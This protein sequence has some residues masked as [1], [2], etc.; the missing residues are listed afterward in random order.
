MPE[1]EHKSE[2]EKLRQNAEFLLK[3]R[4]PDVGSPFS[5]I[6]MLTLIHELE[7][8][9]IE[10]E[11]QNHELILS[12]NRAT[13]A[14]D[15]Y[16][17]LYDFAPVGYFTL[18]KEGEILE[19]NLLGAKM[20]GKER[21][22]IKRKRIG[23]YVSPGSQTIFNNFLKK[24]F[25][26][27]IKENCEITLLVQ[28][29]DAIILHAS[30]VISESGKECLLTVTDITELKQNEVALK[31]SI[32]K[33]TKIAARVPGVVYQ[34][35]LHPDG[36]SCFPYSSEAMKIIYGVTPEDIKEDASAVFAVIHPD[37]YNNLAS[38][39]AK[40]AKDLSPWQHEY[41][42][43]IN[44]GAIRHLLGSALP[45]L[46][47]D[48]SVLWHGFITDITN[49]VE[50]E[51]LLS[52]LGKQNTMAQQIGHTGSW[53]Y[54]IK[55]DKITGSEEAFKI[56]GL[57]NYSTHF[58]L[59]EIED[60]I[61]DRERVHQ[62]MV[63]L[64]KDGTEYHLQYVIQPAD[65]SNPKTVLSIAQL[66]MDTNGQ[67]IKVMGY[68]QDISAFIK[69]QEE[70]EFKN[71]QLYKAIAEKDKF[72]SIIAHDLRSPFNGFLGLTQL[73]VDDL[74]T[75][76]IVQIRQMAVLMRNSAVNV[77]SLLE[78]LLAW[79]RMQRGLI[80]FAPEK[81]NLR[82]KVKRILEPVMESARKKE[83]ETLWNIPEGIH[84]FADPN[85]F[86]SIMRNLVGNAVKF[87]PT[88]GKFIISAR[89]IDATT[90]EISVKDNGIGMCREMLENLFDMNEH[91]NRLGTDGEL[92]S[93]LGLLLCKEFTELNGG[94][95]W[96]ESIENGG[97]TFYFTV[98]MREG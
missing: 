67:P 88:G 94:K 84:F 93:G 1:N 7:V 3:K 91:N 38:S 20:L 56:F 54:E 52:K 29:K 74:S 34:Y 43:K 65:G 78:N 25:K 10:L 21:S 71:I 14:I 82:D 97:S 15:K 49:R 63:D 48:G 60:H 96:V 66:E 39:I 89:L 28:G 95:L 42:V 4:G 86:S 76:D 64:I 19:L 8:H 31:H 11:M 44:D 85:M 32:D 51:M 47:E 98:P 80:V 73:L 27:Q 87:T 50:T 36:S 17:E 62:A 79:S 24:I 75:L 33:L 92:S 55:A 45:E 35:R 13:L 46:E 22:V 2:I 59:N 90:I 72:F 9:Q 30:G 41:R 12:Q 53:E 83:I 70:L 18:S 23:S 37:D 68:I 57:P 69:I 26:N 77:F 61:Q 40:S 5:E 6:E 16:T 81:F 58:T